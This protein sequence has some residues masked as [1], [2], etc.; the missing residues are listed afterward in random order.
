MTMIQIRN[1]SEETHRKLKSRAALEGR[2]LSDYLKHEIERLAERPGRDE[3][4]QRLAALQPV[5]LPEDPVGA[6]REERGRRTE[7]LARTRAG[8]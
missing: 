5:D 6:A 4:L 8:S 7:K 2:S 1:V 3:L